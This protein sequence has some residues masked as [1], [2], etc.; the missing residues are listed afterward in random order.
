M[1]PKHLLERRKDVCLMGLP[2][3]RV[4]RRFVVKQFRV[5]W[6]CASCGY[7]HEAPEP[8]ESCPVCGREHAPESVCSLLGG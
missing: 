4:E 8:P 2:Y 3:R 5:A 7:K 1:E 6:K